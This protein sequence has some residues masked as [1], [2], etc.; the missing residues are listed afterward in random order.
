MFNSILVALDCSKDCTPVVQ[1]L[2]SLHLSPQ[3]RLHLCHI[4]SPDSESQEDPDRPHRFSAERF[5]RA[6]QQLLQYQ[7]QLSGSAIEIVT[8]DPAEE[9]LRLAN[10]HQVELILLGNRGLKG[11]ERVIS[12]SVSGQVLAE[13]ACSVLVVHL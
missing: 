13:A 6:E 7:S 10:I 3:I 2:D 8:G 9:I 11:V 4:L 1:T 12:G 5:Q